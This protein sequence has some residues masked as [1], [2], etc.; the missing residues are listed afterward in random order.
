MMKGNNVDFQQ[1]NLNGTRLMIGVVPAEEIAKAA[2][3]MA[4]SRHPD[5]P[6]DRLVWLAQNQFWSHAE[7]ILL[8]RASQH[9]SG[10]KALD[11]AVKEL[12]AWRKERSRDAVAAEG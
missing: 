11:E 10:E 2:I 6:T 3:A 9:V 8:E 4:L 7:A 1:I 5:A 12:L